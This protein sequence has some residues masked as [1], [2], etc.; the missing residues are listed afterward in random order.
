MK[1]QCIQVTPFL[2]YKLI[3]PEAFRSKAVKIV[4]KETGT[5]EYVIAYQC[6]AITV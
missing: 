3:L 2:D 5:L 4:L 1:E 6:P